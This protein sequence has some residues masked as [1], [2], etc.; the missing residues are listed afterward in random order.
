MESS[1][2]RP[3][4]PGQV[5]DRAGINAG[6]RYVRFFGNHEPETVTVVK[7]PFQDEEGYWWMGA[8]IEAPGSDWKV[9]MISLADAGVVPYPGGN[10]H[11]N[12]YL[13][14]QEQLAEV[15][16]PLPVGAKTTK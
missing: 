1:G 5:L 6:G 9:R 4:K 16:T 11:E 15:Q 3:V 2:D 7:E 8:R 13:V 10:W 12:N 14:A